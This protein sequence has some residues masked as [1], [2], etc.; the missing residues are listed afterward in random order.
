[1][2]WPHNSMACDSAALQY[3][4]LS[5]NQFQPSARL[6]LY[7]DSNRSANSSCTWLARRSPAKR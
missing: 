4:N 5:S 3:V 7:R 6:S 2:D 1:M